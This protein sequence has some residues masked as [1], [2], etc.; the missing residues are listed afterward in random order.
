MLNLRRQ[1]R[2]LFPYWSTRQRARWVRAMLNLG[3]KHICHPN[4]QV[5]RKQ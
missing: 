1:S 3:D 2:A 4:N 5:R